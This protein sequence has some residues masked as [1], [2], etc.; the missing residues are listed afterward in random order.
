MN[1]EG[2]RAQDEFVRHKMLDAIGDLMLAGGPLAGSY[3]ANQPGHALNSALVRK[4][5]S[6]PEAWCW[7]VD[8]G[9]QLER[10]SAGRSAH[11]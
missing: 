5:I 3:E 9:E 6:T 8:E 2:L 4:L 10:K 7:E 1:P 11:A